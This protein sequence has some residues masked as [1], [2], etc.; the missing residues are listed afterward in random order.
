MS[1]AMTLAILVAVLLSVS[2]SA[3]NLLSCPATVTVSRDTENSPNLFY[4]GD[5]GAIGLA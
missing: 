1:F 4:I 3:V 5:D 2:A